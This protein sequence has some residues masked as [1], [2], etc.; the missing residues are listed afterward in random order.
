V[1]VLLRPF[2]NKVAFVDKKAYFIS[3]DHLFE[4]DLSN[5]NTSQPQQA[6]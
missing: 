6:G 5:Q 4:I 1:Q 3:L 2:L